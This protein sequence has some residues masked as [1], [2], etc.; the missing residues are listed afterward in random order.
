MSFLDLVSQRQSDRAFDPLKSIE[1]DKLDRILQAA[2]LAPSACNAQPWRFIVV[3][4]EN[5]RYQIADA[6]STKML[7]INHFTKQA[8]IHIIIIEEPANFSS[9]IGSFFKKKHFPHIDIGIVAEHICL[10]AAEE[11]LGSCMIGW[12]DEKKIK[13]ILNIPS[14]R[15]VVLDIVIGY[16]TQSLRPK[17]RK[18]IDKLVSYDKY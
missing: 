7:G 9:Q 13:K 14:S 17:K 12:F 18:E 8:P 5:L 10:A 11:G 3:K 6:T 4:D 2:Q 16:S 15:N 1:Q